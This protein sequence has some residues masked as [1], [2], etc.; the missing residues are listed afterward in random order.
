MDPAQPAQ[1]HKNGVH[2]VPGGT[3]PCI[4]IKFA[5]SLIIRELLDKHYW[6]LGH[7]GHQL[8]KNTEFYR[9][10]RPEWP[11]VD[12]GDPSALALFASFFAKHVF[13]RVFRIPLRVFMSFSAPSHAV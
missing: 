9:T 7:L 13:L 12:H 11:Q 6:T 1:A 10:K 8:A 2:L 5:Q 4:Y 3:T